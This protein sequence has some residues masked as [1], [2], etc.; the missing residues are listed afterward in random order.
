MTRCDPEPRAGRREHVAAADVLAAVAHVQARRRPAPPGVT[1]PS[2]AWLSS[3][4]RIASAPAGTAAPVVMPSAVPGASGSGATSP[5]ATS[6]A[7]ASGAGGSVSAAR[8]A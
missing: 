8:S 3:T 4:R 2:A 7:S 1:R 6:P 5:A